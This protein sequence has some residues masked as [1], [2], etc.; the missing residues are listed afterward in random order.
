MGNGPQ[1]KQ[2]LFLFL[3]T[4]YLFWIQ[5]VKLGGIE[6][7]SQ[8]LTS[9]DTRMIDDYHSFCVTKSLARAMTHTY[10]VERERNHLPWHLS[11]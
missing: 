9:W 2:I 8:Q 1:L 6:S 5:N 10:T 7:K 11:H 4:N 3:Y